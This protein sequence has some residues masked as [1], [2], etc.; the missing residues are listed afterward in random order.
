ML[1]ESTVLAVKVHAT[2]VKCVRRFVLWLLPDD[3]RQ[4]T[5]EADV[6]VCVRCSR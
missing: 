3:P 4:H 6:L 2:C 5:P 1:P